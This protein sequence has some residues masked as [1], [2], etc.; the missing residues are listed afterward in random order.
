[1]PAPTN[2]IKQLLNST[3][4]WLRGTG[5]EHDV[6]ISSRIRLARN[7][8][9]FLFHNKLDADHESMII[10]EVHKAVKASPML[11][12]SLFFHYKDLKENDKQFLFERH[13]ISPE[14]ARG[15][16]KK[17]LVVSKNEVISIMVLEEDHLR[18]QSFQS[19]FNLMEAWRV[20]DKIDTELEAQ[21]G[22]AFDSSLGY[23]TACPTNV[24][25]GLR[26][27]CMLHLPCLVTTKQITKVLQA[28]AKL[29]MAVRGLYGE[30][31]QAVGNFF[32]FSN[33]ITLGQNEEDIIDNLERVIKQVIGHEK[34]SREH[35][36]AKKRDKLEDQIWRSLGTLKSARLLSSNEAISLLSLLRLGLDIKF[37]AGLTEAELNSLFLI[38]QPAHLQKM[39]G[40]ELSSAERDY[41]R[42]E[43]FRDRLKD[44]RL[45]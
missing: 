4:E 45:I 14:H 3:S 42:A 38:T 34:E 36:V 12:D 19:G 2:G 35:L 37:L 27:S 21:L 10:E 29:G 24:G 5:P 9:G 39:F 30:G 8:S 23:L 20:I 1:M 41:K 25:T 22:F 26:A 40:S 13:L 32:Q 16:G 11:K 28:V 17:A 31:T 18:I 43:L 7:I 6:V 44:V 33:Q 15:K